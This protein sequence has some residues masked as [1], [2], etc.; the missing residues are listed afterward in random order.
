MEAVWRSG[1][2]AERKRSLLLEEAKKA[3][4]ET[5]NNLKQNKREDLRWARNNY[6]ITLWRF[7]GLDRIHNQLSAAIISITRASYKTCIFILLLTTRHFNILQIPQSTWLP[8][9]NVL[10]LWQIFVFNFQ[11]KWLNTYVMCTGVLCKDMI[12]TGHQKQGKSKNKF[13]LVLAKGRQEGK[14]PETCKS[15]EHTTNDWEQK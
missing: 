11:G 3:E 6:S 14:N 13:R 15:C 1:V 9:A 12:C 4:R 2:S 8:T 7:S 5:D 10:T